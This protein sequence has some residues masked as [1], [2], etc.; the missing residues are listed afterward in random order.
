MGFLFHLLHNHIHRELSGAAEEHQHE[1]C[2]IGDCWLHLAERVACV[3]KEQGYAHC[4]YQR[5]KAQTEQG[6]QNKT[7][8]TKD[9][10][11]DCQPERECSA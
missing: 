9:F 7:E 4:K 1:D 5:D 11:E 6:S 3:Y 8:S 2:E 10:G